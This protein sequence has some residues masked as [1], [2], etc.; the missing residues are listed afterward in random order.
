MLQKHE[1]F[2]KMPAPEMPNTDKPSAKVNGD[3]TGDISG[4]NQCESARSVPRNV[5]RVV[6]SEE[7]CGCFFAQRALE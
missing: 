6:V 3:L 7:K 2:N 4:E 5:R 1:D